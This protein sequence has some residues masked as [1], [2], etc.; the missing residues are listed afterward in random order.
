MGDLKS[1]SQ[2]QVMVSIL[3][4]FNLKFSNF[5]IQNTEDDLKTCGPIY[6]EQILIIER[7]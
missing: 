7:T 4:N 5:E 3:Y 2:P 6:I 1:V